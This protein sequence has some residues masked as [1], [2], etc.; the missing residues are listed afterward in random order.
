CS[1][2]RLLAK[3]HTRRGPARWCSTLFR[4]S[5]SVSRSRR[6]RLRVDHS[7]TAGDELERGDRDALRN[8]PE[9]ALREVRDDATR[10]D[11]IAQPQEALAQAVVF[12][13][14]P[15]DP[16]AHVDRTKCD[17][18][19]TCPSIVEGRTPGCQLTRNQL[20]GD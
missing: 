9:N 18:F 16:Q 2:R 5:W 14:E 6:P 13:I 1:A 12:G 17:V 8:R 3:S 20:G 19:W 10:R 15:F 11:V 4:V 7:L